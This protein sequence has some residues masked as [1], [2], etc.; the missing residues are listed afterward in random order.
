M[1]R[2]HAGHGGTVH[3]TFA[4]MTRVMYA[5]AAWRW[6]AARFNRLPCG[7]QQLDTVIVCPRDRT[8][9]TEWG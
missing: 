2:I 7:T 1:S 8:G 9:V 5:G 4:C 6:K 3:V